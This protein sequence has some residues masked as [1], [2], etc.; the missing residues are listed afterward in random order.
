MSFENRIAWRTPPDFLFLFMF[1]TLP[2]FTYYFLA[3]VLLLSNSIFYIEHFVLPLSIDVVPT[4]PS[5][6]KFL[7]IVITTFYLTYI[8]AWQTAFKPTKC[9]T[10]NALLESLLNNIKWSIAKKIFEESRQE[11]IKLIFVFPLMIQIIYSL[12]SWESYKITTKPISAKKYG[13]FKLFL[14]MY[15]NRTNFM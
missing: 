5:N 9:I 12:L 14:N 6:Q 4:T 7:Y 3:Q 13:V 1:H 15:K 11:N 8:A 2:Y 10:C